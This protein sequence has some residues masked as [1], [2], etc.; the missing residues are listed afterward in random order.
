MAKSNAFTVAQ[1]KSLPTGKHCDG[2]GLWLYKRPDGGA[3]WIF[4]FQLW[5]RQREMGLGSYRSVSLAE[6]RR[7]AQLARQQVLREVDPIK[8]RQI[9]R[10]QSNSTDGRLEHL[11]L[12]AYEKH[13]KSLKHG[14]SDGKW[15]SPLRLHVLPKLGKM[16]I[17]KINQED[18]ARALEPIWHEKPVTAKKCISRL[19]TIFSYASAK[20][21]RVSTAVID[22]AVVILGYNK[23]RSTPHQA[24]HWKDVPAFYATLSD[25]DP[26]QLALRMLILTGVRSDSINNMR[27][28]QLMSSVWIIPPL[29]VKG[30]ADSDFVFDVPLSE[31]HL[32]VIELAKKHSRKGYLFPNA[33]GGPLNKMAMRNFLVDNN[34][35]ARPHGFR[36]SL[37]TWLMDEIQCEEEIAEACI[38]HVR[39]GDEAVDAYKRSTYLPKRTPLMKEWANFVTGNS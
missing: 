22:D 5:G 23:K 11:A 17:V 13:K 25:D 19:R 2:L 15:F 32:H 27:L 29:H 18:I 8:Q 38:G 10:Q 16:P 31:E 21:F 9:N 33:K 26:T 6:A 34:I 7:Q 14:G 36:S 4:R 30:R 20:R 12:E 1:L 28:G 37:R 35:P 3:Q 39:T 24:L